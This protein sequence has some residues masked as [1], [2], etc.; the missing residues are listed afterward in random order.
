MLMAMFSLVARDQQELTAAFE[1][2]LPWARSYIRGYFR[3]LDCDRE[4]LLVDAIETLWFVSLMKLKRGKLIA[5]SLR[6]ICRNIFLGS[7]TGADNA[8]VSN[9][10]GSRRHMRQGYNDSR[11]LVN[12]AAKQEGQALKLD[13]KHAISQLRPKYQ[14]I[15]QMRLAGYSFPAIER[16]LNTATR[17]SYKA[18]AELAALLRDYA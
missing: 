12:L 9:P 10:L 4:R 17:T 8:T 15:V 5:I 3:R 18:Q 6:T 7:I 2:K 1:K 11:T 13:L 14:R 16:L